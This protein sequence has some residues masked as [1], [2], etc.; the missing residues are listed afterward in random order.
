MQAPLV[1]YTA[2][3]FFYLDPCHI[4]KDPCVISHHKND[5]FLVCVTQNTS[6]INWFKQLVSQ[7]TLFSAGR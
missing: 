3:A 5:E 4:N 1:K 7:A 6:L 2:Q